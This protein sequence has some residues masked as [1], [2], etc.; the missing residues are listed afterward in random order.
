MR[1]QFDKKQYEI[2]E[3]GNRSKDVWENTLYV[4]NWASSWIMFV[5]IF[6]VIDS[7]CDTG[8]KKCH[9][10]TDIKRF[11]RAENNKIETCDSIGWQS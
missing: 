3:M 6:D 5:F 10:P 8:Q 11:I 2:H 7:V 4:T 1:T 9:S